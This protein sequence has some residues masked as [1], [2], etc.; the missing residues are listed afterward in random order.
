[1]AAWVIPAVMAGISLIQGLSGS[2]QAKRNAELAMEWGEYN[3]AQAR[4]YADFNARSILAVSS[5]NSQ[6]VGFESEMN[7]AITT[8][9]AKY[10]AALRVQTA[11][12]NAQLLEREAELVWNQQELDQAIWKRESERAMKQTRAKFGSSGIEVNVG[13]PIDYMVDQSTQAKLESFIIRHNA[14]IQMGKLLDA[15][16]LGRWEGEREAANMVFQ[17][18]LENLSLTTTAALKQNQINVQ[19]AYDAVMARYSGEMQANQILFEAQWQAAEYTMSGM[20]SLLAGL[21][22]GGSWAAKSYES[23]KLSQTKD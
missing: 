1:M 3:A 11:E 23:Y 4:R 20:N 7:A 6:M 19:G 9:I 21:F 10:N 17:A 12:Y 14:D 15:A 18:Q 16:A 22:Q 5:I 13:S 2:A 8:E